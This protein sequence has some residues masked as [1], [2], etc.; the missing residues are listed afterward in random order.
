MQGHGNRIGTKEEYFVESIEIS[1]RNEM[2]IRHDAITSP[3]SD[4]QQAMRAHS[5]LSFSFLTQ[6][7]QIGN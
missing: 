2:M 1:K 3:Q 6:I 5:I 7:P 4:I